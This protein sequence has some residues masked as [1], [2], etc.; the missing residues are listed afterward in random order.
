MYIALYF[1]T[2]KCLI[3]I[4]SEVLVFECLKIQ[5]MGIIS[6]LSDTMVIYARWS[7]IC[8]SHSGY[9]FPQ[10]ETDKSATIK[11][12]DVLNMCLTLP[13]IIH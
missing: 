11:G 12:R 3:Q 7:E 2:L 5:I 13:C 10:S 4:L 8:S 6:A 1:Y 9:F